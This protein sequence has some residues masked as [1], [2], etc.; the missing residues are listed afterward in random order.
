VPI[1]KF[2]DDVSWGTHICLFYDTKDDLLDTVVPYFQSGL[3]R[4]EFCVWAVSEP[5]T[6][7][8]AVIALRQ[9]VPSFD[10]FLANRSMEIL[11]GHHWYLEGN[12][13]DLK[14]ITSRWNEKLRS[15]LTKGYKAMRVS[16]NAFWLGT[17]H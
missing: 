13:F 14:R 8:D 4:N 11:S 7:K 16:G 6:E 1:I 2:L 9:R 3:E 17:K 10:R 15:A 5:L 12:R